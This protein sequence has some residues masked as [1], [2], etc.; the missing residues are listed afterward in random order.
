MATGAAMFAIAAFTY[1][2]KKK[3]IRKQEAAARRQAEMN[4]QGIME[5][6]EV[7]IEQQKREHRKTLGIARAV[8][9]ASGIRFDARKIGGV[10]FAEGGAERQYLEPDSIDEGGFIGATGETIYDQSG[11]AYNLAEKA[12]GTQLTGATEGSSTFNYLRNMKKVFA[13]DIGWAGK[14]GRSRAK[15]ARF[16]GNIASAE[17]SAQKAAA[18]ASFVS[19]AYSAY[20]A[21]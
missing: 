11:G 20:Q 13:E 15:V 3:A 12:F 18:T 5:E 17:A 9:A 16:G 7:N 1:V 14:I 21:K 8:A 19:S 2:T 4:A 6:T 10:S